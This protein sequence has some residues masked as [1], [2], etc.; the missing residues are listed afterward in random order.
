MA[1]IFIAHSRL[2]ED[3]A[4][5]VAERL[6]SLGY[7]VARA[8]KGAVSEAE[9]DAARA[10]LGNLISRYTFNY[11]SNLGVVGWTGTLPGRISA[12]VRVGATQRYGQSPYGVADVYL[13]RTEGRVRPFV[14]LTNFTDTRYQ[15]IAGVPM[16][17]RGFMAGL[18]WTVWRKR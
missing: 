2:D 14:Q 15:E 12:R 13:A 16:P 8:E 4:L 18:E 5:P 1:D 6:I 10:V 11:A 9:L 3:R 17:G 7:S